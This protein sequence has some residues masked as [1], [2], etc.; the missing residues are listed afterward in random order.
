MT[1]SRTSI[2]QTSAVVSGEPVS[3]MA[4]LLAL[5]IGCVLLTCATWFGSLLREQLAGDT[6][7]IE[8]RPLHI[9]D[10]SRALVFDGNA[11]TGDVRVLSVRSGITEIARLH[12]DQRQNISTLSLD[13]QGRVLT[14]ESADGRYQYDTQTFRLLHHSP[15]LALGPAM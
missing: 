9:V 13:A 10:V 11:A 8:D 5:L 3:L 4:G 1:S 12:E 15:I 6:A 2:T 14:V 7:R